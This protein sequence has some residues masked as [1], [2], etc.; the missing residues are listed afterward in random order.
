MRWNFT[1]TEKV[2]LGRQLC[3]ALREQGKIAEELA[4]VKADFKKRDNE[5]VAY[6]NEIVSKLNSGYEMRQIGT[7]KR[8]DFQAA[9]VQ[10]IRTDTGEI[11]EE[12]GLLD[13]ERQMILDV[14]K[15]SALETLNR[16]V[17]ERQE[18]K[19][20]PGETA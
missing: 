7:E 20:P 15:D 14:A 16:A 19:R 4:T 17:R 6:I 8:I 9:I 12:R 1:E 13:A 18:E 10:V 3:E 11:I 2:E 5:V